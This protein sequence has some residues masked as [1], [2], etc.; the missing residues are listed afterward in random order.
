[1][2]GPCGLL[3]AEVILILHR[4]KAAERKDEADL[5]V[6]RPMHSST[7]ADYE[8]LHAMTHVDLQLVGHPSVWLD[9][10]AH[11]PAAFVDA[12]APRVFTE[13]ARRRGGF[14]RWPHRALQHLCRRL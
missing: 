13:V 7:C 11:L 3:G 6:H 14:E 8:T 4:N 9:I 12:R 5:G 10:A 2:S 1:M